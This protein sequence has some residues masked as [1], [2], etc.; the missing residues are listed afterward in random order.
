[1]KFVKAVI[2]SMVSMGGAS[3]FQSGF[4][5]RPSRTAV[6]SKDGGSSL[7]MVD[8]ESHVYNETIFAIVIICLTP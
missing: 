7:K 1:M 8:S 5:A 3:A 4:V 6:V 2:L